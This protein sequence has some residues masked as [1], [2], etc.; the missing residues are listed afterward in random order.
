MTLN[1]IACD[2]FQD[3]PNV[4]Y[5]NNFS[6]MNSASGFSLSGL[7]SKTLLKEA[8]RKKGKGRRGGDEGTHKTKK[9]RT[10]IG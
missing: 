2:S 4:H 3:S 5:H 1:Y 6:N 10:Y 7:D 8:S 9:K